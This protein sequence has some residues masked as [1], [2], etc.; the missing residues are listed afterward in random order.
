MTPS[1]GKLAAVP[2]PVKVDR[3]IAS[4]DTDQA[5]LQT[6]RKMCEY[7]RAG[8][9]DPEVQRCAEY[10]WRRFGLGRSDPAMQA[11][12]VFW[13]VK[14]CI[15]FRVDEAT[16]FRVGTR[17]EQ[18]LLI[19]PALLVRMRDPAEDCD[20]FTMLASAML[21]ALGVPVVIATVA[22]DSRDRGRWS[23]VFPCAM[24]P[25]GVL[26]IDASHGIGPGWMVPPEHIYRWRAYSLDAEPADVQPMRYRGLHQY[27]QKRG[28]GFGDC[29]NVAVGSDGT[30]PDGSIY[31][32]VLDSGGA[33]PAS[34]GVLSFPYV[35]NPSAP[36]PAPAASSAA[37]SSS[38]DNF[39]QSILAQGV[40]LTSAIVTPP[41]YQQTVRDAAGNIVSTTVRAAT[42]G[43]ATTVAASSLTGNTMLWIGG[44][45]LGLAALFAASRGKS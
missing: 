42:P 38:W 35:T 19:A 40:K 29:L 10:A 44:G 41:A 17:E 14:H 23:H 11:W 22:A 20:G 2:L 16:M 6:V 1:T 26:P 12:G 30:C 27:V 13:W 7:I 34:G 21:A 39:I 33:A 5:T 45:L 8:A 43:Q 36:V 31:T 3:E 28:R 9:A 18:D 4:Q 24:L 37:A 15:K 25:S 32:G